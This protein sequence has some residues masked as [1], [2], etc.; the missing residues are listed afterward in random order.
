MHSY[1]DH[2]HND[3]GQTNVNI[4]QLIKF[5]GEISKIIVQKMKDIMLLMVPIQ[6]TDN[7]FV[8]EA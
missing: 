8:V 3:T 2:F 5:I 1:N 4:M 6:C 7:L